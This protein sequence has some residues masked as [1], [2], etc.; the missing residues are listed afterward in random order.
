MSTKVVKNPLGYYELET[1]P[2]QEE[3]KAYYADK[4]YQSAQGS[5]EIAYSDAEKAYFRNKIAQKLIAANPHL[6]LSSARAPRFLDV[7]AGEGWA[8]AY[9]SEQRWDCVGLDYSSFACASQ[10]PD[11][12]GTMQVG[13]VYEN[14]AAL[15]GA[16]ERFDLI[17]LDNVLE[18]VL[19]PLALL[20]ELRSLLQTGGVLLVEVPNDF[21][22]L[23]QY[24]LDHE[25]IDRLFWVVAPDHISYFGPEGLTALSREAGWE[26]RDL[27]SDYPID[28]GLI[29]PLTN[30]VMDRSLGK[31]CHRARIEAE[32]LFHAISPEKTVGL[33]R[34]LADLGLGRDLTVV[35]VPKK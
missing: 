11:I 1:R 35:L 15:I 20:V 5:Y 23:Q 25:H 32:N 22:R 4:Y 12:A 26:V 9:F 33:Y 8:L 34:A 18:H 14:M 31:P 16:G 17:L 30:Y 29:N 6:D 13:D 2:T 21:S 10:N 7:G 3:L 28:L 27:I 19:D 24:L